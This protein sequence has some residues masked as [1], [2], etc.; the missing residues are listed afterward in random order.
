M[1]HN[2]REMKLSEAHF[3]INYF[4]EADHSFLSA[5]GV[6]PAK[7]PQFDQWYNIL[8]QDFGRSIDDRHFFYLV[9]ELDGVP[10]GHS[11]INNIVYAKEAFMHLHIWNPIQRKTGHGTLF[12]RESIKIYFELFNLSQ[13]FCQPYALNPAPNRTLRKVGFKY[14]KTYETTPGWINFPQPVNL[15]V[16]DR[17]E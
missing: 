3:M 9:W 5:L 12:V 4:L 6:D 11:N 1:K 16:L 17:A 7:L 2:V 14:L 13:L 8:K 10:I 15:W